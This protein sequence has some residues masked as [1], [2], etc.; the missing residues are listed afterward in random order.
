M[1]IWVD[2]ELFHG[3]PGPLCRASLYGSRKDPM[4]P[5]RLRALRHFTDAP[6]I[7]VFGLAVGLLTVGA[8]N[9]QAGEAPDYVNPDYRSI[10]GAPDSSA[11]SSTGWETDDG[12]GFGGH[13]SIPE[14]TLGSG[15]SLLRPNTD[16]PP[17]SFA[18]NNHGDHG[19]TVDWR[20]SG[21]ALGYTPEALREMNC[22]EILPYGDLW[23]GP[24]SVLTPCDLIYANCF[25]EVT[26]TCELEAGV[27]CESELLAC[28]SEN[29]DCKTQST[30]CVDRAI[31]CFNGVDQCYEQ[32]CEGS[33]CDV[34][35]DCDE[36]YTKCVDLADSCPD[37]APS[38][39]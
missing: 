7:Q 25:D 3:A 2:C 33:D 10:P 15:G 1:E 17:P 28:A 39:P 27:D 6:R 20:G 12:D 38:E 8:C 14:I 18:P 34:G 16:P 26:A 22:R 31:A 24:P 29:I 21:D 11:G 13:S 5:I 37:P 36:Q 32:T 4:T 23:L 9:S 35:I 19:C 30:P